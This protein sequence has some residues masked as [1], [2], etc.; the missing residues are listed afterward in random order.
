MQ[1]WTPS[2]A[3]TTPAKGRLEGF[4]ALARLSDETGRPV[5]PDLFIAVAEDTGLIRPLGHQVLRQACRQLAAWRHRH[6]HADHLTVAVNLSARQAQH[7]SL[8]DEVMAVLAEEGL[9][10][11]LLV[12]E[13]TESVL[14]QAGRSTITTF[15]KLRDAGI[16]IAIDDFGT[17][18]AS[19]RY[20]AELPVSAVKI[21]R[22]FTAGL[23]HDPTC[24]TIVRAVAGLA[25]DLDLQCVVE[26]VETTQQLQALPPGASVQ[27]YLLGRPGTVAAGSAAIETG[28]ARAWPAHSVPAGAGSYN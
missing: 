23:P 24:A 15:H 3:T 20:L 1:P 18:Y 28:S 5:P 8:A 9:P 21:D 22:S 13:L 17:G 4:E 25:R 7:P 10:A 14:L 2:T 27:G 19:L 26:G 6:A 16:G 12:L 11:D